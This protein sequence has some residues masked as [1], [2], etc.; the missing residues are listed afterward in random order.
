MSMIKVLVEDKE[1][2]VR[3]DL[4]KRSKLITELIAGG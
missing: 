4:F 2:E 3:E 1:L